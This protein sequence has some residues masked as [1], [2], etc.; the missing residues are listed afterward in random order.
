MNGNDV[1]AVAVFTGS[2]LAVAIGMLIFIAIL[3]AFT[4]HAI[5]PVVQ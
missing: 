3:N 5:S 1:K 2:F 4:A